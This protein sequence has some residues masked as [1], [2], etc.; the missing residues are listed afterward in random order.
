MGYYS[1]V[2]IGM[3]KS[4]YE[5]FLEAISKIGNVTE[6]TEVKRLFENADFVED[7][8]TWD[9]EEAKVFQFG[10]VKWY[11]EFCEVNFIM[12]F[13]RR[14]NDG[15]WFFLRCGEDITDIETE[16]EVCVFPITVRAKLI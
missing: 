16:G 13:L 10:C 8:E 12:T 4:L 3:K 2:T 15:D 6:K 9:G 11:A 7:M 14:Q 1:E 5:Q